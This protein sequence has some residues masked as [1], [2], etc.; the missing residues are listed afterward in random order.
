MSRILGDLEFVRN[1]I[2]DI[3]IASKDRSDHCENVKLVIERLTEAKLI[4]NIDKCNFYS[5]QV[6]LLGFVINTKGRRVDPNKLV[7]INDWQPPTTGKQVQAYMG[8]FNFFREYMPLISTVA[9]PLDALRNIPGPFVLNE[10]Q[11]RCL[12]H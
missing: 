2:D 1:F 11:L 3:L 4:I 6:S 5:T 8:T 12:M 7:N 9:A 10:L